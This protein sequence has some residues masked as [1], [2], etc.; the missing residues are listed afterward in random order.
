MF[1]SVDD[2]QCARFFDHFSTRSD[3]VER[4]RAVSLSS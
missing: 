4:R 1:N 2:R 3:F